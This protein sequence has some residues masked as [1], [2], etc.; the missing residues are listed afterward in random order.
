MEK[1]SSSII[2]AQVQRLSVRDAQKLLDENEE[3]LLNE[4]LGDITRI[5]SII[6][7]KIKL[8]SYWQDS[9]ALEDI[10]VLKMIA[11]RIPSLV[12]EVAIELNKFNNMDGNLQIELI[13]NLKENEKVN[14]L[15]NYGYRLSSLVMQDIVL[16]L[17]DY[18][19]QREMLEKN[20]NKLTDTELSLLLTFIA[21]LN[22]NN[23]IYFLEL[24]KDE[25]QELPGMHFVVLS[26]IIAS[27]NIEKFYD[28]FNEKISGLGP[29][30][31]STFIAN[32]ELS[33]I[34]I[35]IEKFSKQLNSINS[36]V[37]V[38]KLLMEVSDIT[39]IYNILK[40]NPVM[41]QGLSSA[42][43]DMLIKRLPDNLRIESLTDFKERYNEISIFD[44]L[45][46]FEFDSDEIKYK[47]FMEYPNKV[48]ELKTKQFIKYIMDNFDQAELRNKI[49]LQY[50]DKIISSF[51]EV[52]IYFI[53][54]YTEKELRNAPFWNEND[55]TKIDIVT[56]LKDN[57]GRRIKSI[58]L[59]FLPNF[60]N[61]I[62]RDIQEYFVDYLH[63]N[64]SKIIISKRY[65]KDLIN[66]I[67]YQ[68]RTNLFQDFSSEFKTLK[69]KDWYNIHKY[70]SSIHVE[71]IRNY[72]NECE[73]DSFVCPDKNELN[74]DAMARFMFH[75]FTLNIE[76]H[77]YPKYY[78]KQDVGSLID[79]Y[80]EMV[81]K[82]IDA[83][84]EEIL[85]S[86]DALE[87][88]L[89]LRVLFQREIISDQDEYYIRYKEF[90]MDK[91]F[92]TL[93]IPFEE[94]KNLIKDSIFYRLVKG[95]IKPVTL[96]PIKTLKG[97][98]FFNKNV[99]S[100]E[101]NPDVNVYHPQEIE[102]VT[103]VL[104]DAQ[105]IGLNNKLFKQLCK[106][107]KEKFI[108]TNPTKKSV[109]ALAIRMYLTVGFNNAKKLL[110]ISDVPFQNYEYTFSSI[111]LERIKLDSNGEPIINKRLN[112]F[113]FSSRFKDDN[114][115]IK[116]VLLNI[117]PEFSKRF[118]EVY[119]N[120]PIIYE[121]LNG[122]VSVPRLLKY[123]ESH[124]VTLEPDEYRLEAVIHEFGSRTR[125]IEEARRLYKDMR[126][127]EYSIIPKTSGSYKDYT[128]Q[129]LDLDDPLGLA[130]GYIT[131]CCFL[132]DGASSSS[133]Y[134]SA[135]SNNGRIFVVWRDG[136]L[137]AQSWM[138]RIGNLL[139]FDNVETTK[140]YSEE[141][142]LTVYT[143][144]A[145]R[146]MQISRQNE[147]VIEQIKLV[148]FG[149]DYSKI[150]K[151]DETVPSEEIVTPEHLYTDAHEQFILATAGAK[152][153][154]YGDVKIKYRDER[155]APTRYFD[156]YSLDNSEKSKVIKK[157]RSIDFIK[158]K[159]V[160]TIDFSNYVYAVIA[161]DWYLLV[162]N[163]N[164]IECC[165]LET[166]ERILGEI[167]KEIDALDKIFEENKVRL[168]SD[169]IKDSVLS[170][171]KGGN[172][173]AR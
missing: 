50:K 7:M 165:Y 87:V 111:D 148:T 166:D 117:V 161:D 113:L 153:L 32:Q 162:T 69:A 155:P 39:I 38:P 46:L 44:L 12:P 28:L 136:I 103:D 23:Q 88:L 163:G 61:S 65:L 121:E 89:L 52:F 86:F 120:W 90:F 78:E 14:L 64:I 80:H 144:A 31:F 55:T 156:L 34:N 15:N 73:I 83:N 132:I 125:V 74:D 51:D 40:A 116:K 142:L 114:I 123:F 57:F 173:N 129:V 130:V 6:E 70:V 79:R 169:S 97:L 101:K 167:Y 134:H 3:Q 41:L 30:T 158:N 150:A 164:E 33:G 170:L 63:D 124:K 91:L 66:S 21:T 47:F 143:E 154:Y 149:G 5:L 84:P 49:L 85:L 98:V 137:V 133:L 160:R 53:K 59:K 11:T 122:N 109:R 147:S 56:F 140:D 81:A 104:T 107:I 72:L 27:E 36:N 48:A 157:I 17:N 26:T 92:A 151:P 146:L 105:V 54:V 95:G 67:G 76:N 18:K 10:F 141:D 43:F 22:I 25:I 128:F 99:V 42:Y 145:F 4:S 138:W 93:D 9:T 171:V 2:L 127:R 108:D 77:L 96:L 172:N 62:D 118:S 24:I 8:L 131:R 20:K 71:S 112:D 106:V 19:I 45:S 16:S 94:N 159:E 13:A 115:N 135:Q 119:N 58:H 102:E 139:C 100:N 152:N 60:F 168:N 35:C 75:N 29:D 68:L 37:I 82:V 126:S 110:E 1:I